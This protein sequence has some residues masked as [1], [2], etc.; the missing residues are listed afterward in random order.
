MA[1]GLGF[2]VQGAGF[3]VKGSGFGSMVHGLC[4]RVTLL[5]RF[6]V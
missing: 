4:C 3:K 5:S 2:R 6:R 1:K